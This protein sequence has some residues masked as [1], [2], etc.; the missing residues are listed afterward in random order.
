MSSDS[1]CPSAPTPRIWDQLASNGGTG[2]SYYASNSAALQTTLNSVFTSILQSSGSS[3]ALAYNSTSVGTNTYVYQ[4]SF[5]ATDWTGKL[6]AYQITTNTSGGQTT[7]SVSSTAQW[8]A[9]KLIPAAAS[10]NILTWDGT[11]GQSFRGRT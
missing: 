8:Q 6:D 9:S 1:R 2:L 10:R 4:A 7:S 5:D 3:S 11:Q